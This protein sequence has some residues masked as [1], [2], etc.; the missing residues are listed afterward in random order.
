[1]PEMNEILDDPELQKQVAGY[2]ITDVNKLAEEYVKSQ[3]YF[4]SQTRVPSSNAPQEE[5]DKYY[6]KIGRPADADGYDLPAESETAKALLE[7]I[8]KEA[9]TSGVTTQQWES[10]AKALDSAQSTM[11][12]SQQE[13]SSAR[14][15]EWEKASRERWGDSFDE[16][17]AK[18]RSVVDKMVQEDPTLKEVLEDSGL[19]NHP[20]LI[21]Y[22]ARIADLTGPDTAPA[23]LDG[24]RMTGS[25]KE[26]QDLA[27]KAQALFASDEIRM[28]NHPGRKAAMHQ[29]MQ[30]EKQLIEMG[31]ERGSTDPALELDAGF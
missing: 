2:G 18:G 4:S 10:L 27:I 17:V 30:I 31:Y 15:K 3:A 29:Y 14:A 13:A 1:M 28:D 6:S 23:S 20:S 25:K 9:H 22:M 8:R 26:A 19:A 12:Q 21:D 16:V 11:D 24:G 7:S 5:W